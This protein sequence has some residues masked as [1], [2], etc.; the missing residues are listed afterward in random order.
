MEAEYSPGA[1]ALALDM[2][3]VLN[4]DAD[5]DEMPQLVSEYVNDIYAYLRDLER[6]YSVRP[7]YLDGQEITFKIASRNFRERYGPSYR[8]CIETRLGGNL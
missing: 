4:I 3:N 5:D 2:N 8:G 1:A 7:N 6:K